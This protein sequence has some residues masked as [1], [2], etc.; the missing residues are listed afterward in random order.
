MKE[1]V[2]N[3]FNLFEDQCKNFIFR[4]KAIIENTNNEILLVSADG[5]YFLPGGHVEGRESFTTCLRRELLE[6]TG[7]QFEEI[8]DK[9]ICIIK[10]IWKDFPV[11]NINSL[12]ISK[13]YA[14]KKNINPNLKVLKLTEEEKETGFKL[15][16]VNKY[17]VVRVLEENLLVC[18]NRAVV[19]DTL[20]AV[21][22]YL[23]LY[24]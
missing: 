1:I 21:K 11:E 17:E 2:H 6:E 7:V 5:D 16:F 20:N 19:D 18:N 10:H 13:Y 22:E 12:L 8:A 23:Y 4:A 15:F 9:P 14:L 3:E 24:S